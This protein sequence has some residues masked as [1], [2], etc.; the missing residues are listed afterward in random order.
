MSRAAMLHRKAVIRFRQ[1]DFDGAR[2]GFQSAAAIAPHDPAIREGLAESLARLRRW[3]EAEAEARAA[4]ELAP[5]SPSLHDL[6][7]RAA[8]E[9]IDHAA[10][11]THLGA[12]LAAR[13]A[14]AGTLVNLSRVLHRVGEWEAAVDAGLAA[15]RLE[16]GLMP[17]RLGLSLAL[18]ALGRSEEA[19]AV[20]EPAPPHPMVRFNRGFILAHLGRLEEGLALM[21]ARLELYDP[22]AGRGARWR[23]GP[24]AGTLLVVPEQGLGDLLLMC[25]FLP[26]LAS[27]ADRVIVVTPPP[28]LRL[29]EAAFPGLRIVASADGVEASA[30]VSM[31]SLAHLAGVRTRS[32]MPAAPWLTLASPQARGARPRIGL[33][34]AGNPRYPYD[35]IRSTPLDR[36]APL[37]ED[38]GAEWVSLH[39]GVREAE[40]AVHGLPEPLAGAA[41]FLDTARVMGG[42]DLVVSTETAIP[43]LSAALGIPTVVLTHPAPDWRW[44]HGHAGITVAAQ[45]SVG[46][47]ST[48]IAIAREAVRSVVAAAAA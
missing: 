42:L 6:L 43:N 14:H 28:L 33:N 11:L 35:S 1:G 29:F 38:S 34:W 3:P 32:D 41:D 8:I 31:M 5:G 12:S 16:P 47:W 21:E 48:P 24:V 19:L 4:L 10:A 17:A 36:L 22:G 27:Q 7:G 26:A 45:T 39:R 2:R 9:R 44:L 25:G 40:A 46:D 20:L 18:H 30:H 23:G 13:P 37:L 15:L